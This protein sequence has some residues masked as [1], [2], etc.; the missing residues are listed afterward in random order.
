MCTVNSKAQRWG[1]AAFL[2]DVFYDTIT[3]VDTSKMKRLVDPSR[4]NFKL[5]T[6]FFSTAEKQKFTVRAHMYQA[7]SLI[8]SDES[9]LSGTTTWFYHNIYRMHLYS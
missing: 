8:G 3:V 4:F 2:I 9:G 1:G 5:F 6:L 7:R